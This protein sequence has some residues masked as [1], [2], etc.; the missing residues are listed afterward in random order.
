MITGQN[1]FVIHGENDAIRK[2]V[3]KSISKNNGPSATITYTGPLQPMDDLYAEVSAQVLSDNDAMGAATYSYDDGIATITCEWPTADVTGSSPQN[4]K[5]G[6]GL[7]TEYWELSATND[8]INLITHPYFI[9]QLNEGNTSRI[10]LN[11]ISKYLDGDYTAI[12][13]YSELDECEK[14]YWD[15]YE[16][17][18]GQIKF[19]FPVLY[20]TKIVTSK[21]QIAASWTSVMRPLPLETIDP[22]TALL[23]AISGPYFKATPQWV[24]QSPMVKQID[25][26]RWEISQSY[27]W[28]YEPF[29]EDI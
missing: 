23:G 1:T 10:I 17:G 25:K 5:E 6:D 3:T 22:P 18:K 16:K 21:S 14:K 20:H 13:D 24:K 19:A 15:C 2:G 27:E 7:V 12:V 8:T 26:F 28:E 9:E 29:N 4:T 11:S